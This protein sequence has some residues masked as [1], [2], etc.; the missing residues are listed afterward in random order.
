MCKC[1][2]W[3]GLSVRSRKDAT[4]PGHLLPRVDRRLQEEASSEPRLS[5][6]KQVPANNSAVRSSVPECHRPRKMGAHHGGR[7]VGA[8]S[9]QPCRKLT[10][11]PSVLLW[12]RLAS[13][14]TVA[15]SNGPPARPPA[16]PAHRPRGLANPVVLTAFADAAVHIKARE[17]VSLSP[18]NPS[19][20]R[21]TPRPPAPVPRKAEAPHPTPPL[22]GGCSLRPGQGPS[23]EVLG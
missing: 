7:R 15:S 1:K 23:P 3:W 4:V 8:A 13:P 11:L 14:K 21:L 20:V 10:C 6:G 17:R 16:R 5:A 2:H 22:S 12:A 18:V 19:V 9:R